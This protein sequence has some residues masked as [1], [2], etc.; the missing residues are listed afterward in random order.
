[1]THGVDEARQDPRRVGDGF[2]AAEL[3]FMPP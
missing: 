2:A 1:M 3:H